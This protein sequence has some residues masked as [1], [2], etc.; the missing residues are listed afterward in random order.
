MST[1]V[2]YSIQLAI[3]DGRLENFRS[4]TKEMV[5]ST[6][7]EPGA[8]GY[9]WFLDDDGTSCHIWERYTDSDAV[10]EHLGTFSSRFAERF[11]ECAEPTA[12]WVYGDPNE[13]VRGVLDGFGAIYLRP[14][15]GFSR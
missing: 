13:A 6:R 8:E 7:S 10:M 15:G 2:S 3:R 1:T 11:L 4:L 12:V 9:E 5:D 14:F